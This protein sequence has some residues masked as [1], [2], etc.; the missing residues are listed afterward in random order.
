MFSLYDS[1]NLFAKVCHVLPQS[2]SVMSTE[3]TVALKLGLWK[4]LVH[5]QPTTYLIKSIWSMHFL[6]LPFF[7]NTM[8]PTASEHF[9]SLTILARNPRSLF[10]SG[11]LVSACT[12]RACERLKVSLSIFNLHIA[13]KR[14]FRFFSGLSS[15]T[16]SAVWNSNMRSF[17]SSTDCFHQKR[18][19][20]RFSRIGIT[21][22]NRVTWFYFSSILSSRIL[23][24]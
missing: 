5:S 21:R 20:L 8:R 19:K 17:K 7:A 18:L 6:G 14:C 16:A 12:Y 11:T 22:I 24:D 23:V 4:R 3:L 1:N 15:F 10:S 13:A 9:R 2:L